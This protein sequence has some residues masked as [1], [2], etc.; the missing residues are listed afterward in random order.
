MR[1]Q[2]LV[3]IA[4]HRKQRFGSLM[5]A[6]FLVILCS[7]P[8]QKKGLVHSF[9]SLFGMRPFLT[10]ILFLRPRLL[11]LVRLRLG[12]FMAWLSV[13]DRFIV[14]RATVLRVLGRT[15]QLVLVAEDL[16]LGLE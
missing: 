11:F 3:D 10:A 2:G 9:L 16:L 15:N 7:F 5:F 4:L 12:V 8:I 14:S 6:F 13:T 1:V